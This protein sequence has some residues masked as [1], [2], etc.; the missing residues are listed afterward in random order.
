MKSYLYKL[1]KKAKKALDITVK[2]KKKDQVLND[3]C[4]LLLKYQSKII[5]ET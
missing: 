1:G 5:S 2:S 3:Y 4:N